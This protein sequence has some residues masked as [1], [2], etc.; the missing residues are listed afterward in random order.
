MIASPFLMASKKDDNPENKETK[1]L[2]V[3]V[4]LEAWTL[5]N[6][7][8][9]AQP[10]SQGEFLEEILEKHLGKHRASIARIRVEEEKMKDYDGKK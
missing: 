5:F 1:Q 3:R 6:K 4:S 7:V 9:R 8:A 2:N 10:K